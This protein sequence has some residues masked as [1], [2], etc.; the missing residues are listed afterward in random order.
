MNIKNLIMNLE[1]NLIMIPEM[2][3]KTNV[4]ISNLK[5]IK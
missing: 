4:N 1:M 3:L 2:N 5:Q